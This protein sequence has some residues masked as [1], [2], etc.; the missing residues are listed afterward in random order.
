MDRSEGREAYSRSTLATVAHCLIY[1][2][3][4]YVAWIWT[5]LGT[6]LVHLGV[7]SGRKQPSANRLMAIS[8]TAS[9]TESLM[10]WCHQF[11]IFALFHHKTSEVP[12]DRRTI[13]C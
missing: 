3:T 6:S 2:S 13:M 10:A 8:A 12:K 5:H 7:V 11:S 4:M 1:C 9:F